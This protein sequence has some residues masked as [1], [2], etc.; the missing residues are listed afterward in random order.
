V[1]V[2][3]WSGPQPFSWGHGG[4]SGPCMAGLSCPAGRG[5]T[6]DDGGAIGITGP[7]ALGPARWPESAVSVAGRRKGHDLSDMLVDRDGPCPG[8]CCQFGDASSCVSGPGTS[9]SFR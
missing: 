8:A 7:D 4:A 6:I 2:S 9:R 1:R 5:H 3:T